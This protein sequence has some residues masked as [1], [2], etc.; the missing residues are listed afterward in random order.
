MVGTFHYLADGCQDYN[1]CSQLVVRE[2]DAGK[3]LSDFRYKRVVCNSKDSQSGYHSLRS[4]IAPLHIGGKYFSKIV[5]SGSHRQSLE[6]LQLKM[7]DI[8]A[9][10]T[11]TWELTRHYEPSQLTGLISIGTTPP[12]PGLP[13]ITSSTTTQEE[14]SKLRVALM[15]LVREAKWQDIREALLIKDFTVTQRDDY[16][17]IADDAKRAKTSGLIAL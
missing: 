14:L 16:Y 5:L 13:L 12:M 1:Y 9:I 15:R 6:F 8:A 2:S 7:A 17:P 10:D 4:L 3:T 11:V